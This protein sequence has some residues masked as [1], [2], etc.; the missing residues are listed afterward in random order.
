MKKQYP[1][2]NNRHVINVNIWYS[3]ASVRNGQAIV[4]HPFLHQLQSMNYEP[5]PP[6]I[7]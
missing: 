4:G 5:H 7:Q 3:T 2:I 6:D 1:H